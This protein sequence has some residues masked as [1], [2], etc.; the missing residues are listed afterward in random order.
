[1]PGSGIAKS[2]RKNLINSLEDDHSEQHNSDKS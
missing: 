1:M 2:K